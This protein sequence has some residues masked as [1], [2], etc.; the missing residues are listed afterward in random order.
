[1]APTVEA[2]ANQTINQGDR[3]SLAPAT[4][5]DSGTADTHTATINW[6]DGT[7]GAGTISASLKTISG[8]HTYTTAGSF[9]VTVTV[10]DDDGASGSDTLTATVNST[11]SSGGS[12]IPS[13]GGAVATSTPTPTPTPT[14]TPT[15]TATVTPTPVPGVPSADTIIS[16]GKDA[17][18]AL[19]SAAVTNVDATGVALASAAAANPTQTGAAI[20]AA[21]LINA[22]AIGLV[23]AKAAESNAGALG[24]ALGTAAES[25]PEAI[26]LAI[27]KAAETNPKGI[28]VALAAAAETNAQAIGVALA[29]AADTNPEGMGEAF[30]HAATTN[31]K[32]IGTA[33]ITAVK[34]NAK[35]IAVA[36]TVGAKIDAA[37]IAEALALGPGVDADALFAL[38][39]VMGIEVWMPETAPVA[40]PDS[41][42]AGMWQKV[43][44]QAPV[45][46]ILALYGDN[47]ASAQVKIEKLDTRPSD[48][49]ALPQG[50]IIGDYVQ[51][52]MDKFENADLKA[53]HVTMSV[54]NNWMSANDIH[55]WS[56][57]FSRYNEDLKIWT[58][59][60]AKRIRKDQSNT[61]YT[62]PP[63]KFSLWAISG[64]TEVQPPRFSV[65]KLTINPSE[66]V[67]GQA[68]NIGVHVTNLTDATAEYTTVI[69]LNSQVHLSRTD[70]IPANGLAE[71]KFV[72]EPSPGTYAVRVDR[73]LGSFIVK[74]A[75]GATP[76]PG[77]TAIPG[78]T[79][80]AT[81]KPIDETTVE[82]VI[83]EVPAVEVTVVVPSV[84]ATVEATVLPGVTLTPT[85]TVQPG[86]AITDGGISF[87]QIIGIV[88][89]A[90]LSV[91]LILGG[92]FALLWKTGRLGPGRR[93]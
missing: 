42:G 88:S 81:V 77:A 54:S 35:A 18:A 61:Y 17:G 13:G 68:S 74:A 60:T 76:V 20:A 78:A 3:L 67:E 62:V 10:T 80:V 48:V 4:Y 23:L 71:I 26:G 28:G 44:S 38:G 90:V 84:E 25:S 82:P 55:P 56:I 47:I 1:V 14:H 27:A 15:P 49:L 92:A 34:I 30:A 63:A 83:A 51:L 41:M 11:T 12:Y 66:F 91:V 7:I 21:A 5:G 73:L 36:L 45:D 39:A 52:S 46:S 53:S 72:T 58:P 65:D 22:D 87:G 31:S 32:A 93:T 70:L 16:E 9:T 43:A 86:E 40:G 29:K 89:L 79:A 64:A 19:A 59:L 2:G 85:P 50:Q 75:P 37:A 24:A 33:L 6:G 69:W 8:I 57:Q